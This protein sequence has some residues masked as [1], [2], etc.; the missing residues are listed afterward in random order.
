MNLISVKENLN[1]E[2]GVRSLS[3]AII[4]ITIGTGIFVIP[5]LIS[6][7]LGAAAILAYLVCGI[8]IFLIALCFA[9]VGSKT[10]ASGG[11]YEYI[12]TAFGPYAGFMSSNLYWLGASVISDG[13]V[14][15][16]LLDTLSSFFPILNNEI[17]RILFFILIFGGLALLN[18]RNV[19][20]GVRFVEFTAFGKL[21]PL[22]LLVL[23]GSCFIAPHNLNWTIE[24]SLS[25]IGSASLLLF[26]AFMGLET[27]LCNGGEIKNPKKTV[28]L[29][30]FYGISGVLI[31]YIAIQLVTQGVLGETIAEHK[32]APL[33]AVSGIVFGKI[34]V[35]LI[36][37]TT[38]ISMLGALGGGILSV[39]RVLFASA[40][41]GL[42][43]KF[44][45]QI[46]P[47]FLT[48]HSAILFYASFG[49]FFSLFGGFKQLAI[50]ASAAGLINY[51]AVVLATIKLRK[52]DTSNS[53]NSFQ[54]PGGLMVPI[55]AV[56]AIVWLLTSLTNEEFISFIVFIA[57]FSFLYL[58]LK[59]L[60]KIT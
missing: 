19:K 8:L 14:A 50:L 1:R 54:I 47:R 37:I 59:S 58:I 17:Y 2:I 26:F 29:G 12:E 7:S 31:L 36:I 42:F 52:K 28:P 11:S 18:I 55:L 60:K 45:A 40:R 24:P 49:L 25:S 33:A 35:T 41:D 30:L 9:E 51:L 23:V 56:T 16:A 6:E 46:H 3:L 44:L 21:L 5:A 39:P 13:A 57:V 38:A 10:S 53:E 20:N 4:N 34:G 48:P 22:V 32:D 15:N 27:P 43:P